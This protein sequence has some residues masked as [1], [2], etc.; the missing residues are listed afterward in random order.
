MTVVE[1]GL[2]KEAHCDLISVQLLHSVQ[3]SVWHS[4]NTFQLMNIVTQC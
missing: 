2:G 3:L 1:T 4:A